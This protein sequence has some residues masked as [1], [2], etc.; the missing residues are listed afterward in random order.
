MNEET[1]QNIS[2]RTR[3]QATDK[4]ILRSYHSQHTLKM[5]T[6]GENLICIKVDKIQ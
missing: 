4:G 6:F 2:G 5:L 3:I 1:T